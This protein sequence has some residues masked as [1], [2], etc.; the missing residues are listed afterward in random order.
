MRTGQHFD[1]SGLGGRGGRFM[2]AGHNTFSNGK[3][4]KLDQDGVDVA[5]QPPAN[6]PKGTSGLSANMLKQHEKRM[7]NSDTLESIKEDGQKST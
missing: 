6:V 2:A 4:S 5:P 3:S 7:E 1:A